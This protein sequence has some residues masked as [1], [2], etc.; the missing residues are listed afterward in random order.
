MK[1]TIFAYFNPLRLSAPQ[2]LSLTLRSS[3]LAGRLLYQ[4][5]RKDSSFGLKPGSFLFKILIAF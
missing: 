3:S 5:E 2:S 1:K 4:E